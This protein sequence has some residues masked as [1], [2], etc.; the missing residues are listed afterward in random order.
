MYLLTPLITYT[1]TYLEIVKK[2]IGNIK[3]VGETTED[4]KRF[5]NLKALAFLT[6]ELLTEIDNVAYR[7]KD[8]HEFSVKR[9]SEF[10]SKFQNEQGIKNCDCKS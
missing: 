10:A 6:D 9:A 2:L 8:S 3:P 4:D 7:Y 5:E 1:M